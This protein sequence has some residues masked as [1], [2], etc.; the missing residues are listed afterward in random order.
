MRPRTWIITLVILAL[1]LNLVPHTW[2]I[3]IPVIVVWFA[4][5]AGIASLISVLIAEKWDDRY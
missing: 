4:V 1:F 3:F 5:S 2:L